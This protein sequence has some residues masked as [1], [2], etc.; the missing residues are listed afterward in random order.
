M[1]TPS[2][3]KQIQRGRRPILYF[4]LIDHKFYSKA[5]ISAMSGSILHAG[6]WLTFTRGLTIAVGGGKAAGVGAQ[7]GVGIRI[8]L[9]GG[10]GSQSVLH[11]SQAA[12]C[13]VEAGG[14]MP[15]GI[16]Y[17]G[18][19][20]LIDMLTVTQCSCTMSRDTTQQP[21]SHTMSIR[22]YS[23]LHTFPCT[24]E[25]LSGNQSSEIKSSPDSTQGG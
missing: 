22:Q 13:I 3:K 10:P 12:A 17:G 4:I 14:A 21:C 2:R 8:I 20:E 16:C 11:G 1:M 25:L 9:P 23:S 18:G 6:F 19:V 24:A 5:I 7:Q 15:V